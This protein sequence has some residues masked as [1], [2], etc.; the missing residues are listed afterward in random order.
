MMTGIDA[1]KIPA[2]KNAGVTKAIARMS[3]DRTIE[4]FHARRTGRE[5]LAQG[6]I[7]GVAAAE[8]LEIHMHSAAHLFELLRE[9]RQLLDV[10]LA[11]RPRLGEQ[12]AGLLQPFEERDVFEGEF[13]LAGIENLKDHHLVL[14]VTQ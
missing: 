1:S 7:Q 2:A 14:L 13:D 3:K 8:T 5:E 6:H 9:Q 10:S 12:F 11:Q 4:L